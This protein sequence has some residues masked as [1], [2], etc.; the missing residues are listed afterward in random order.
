MGVA[1]EMKTA[2]LLVD[3]APIAAAWHRQTTTATTKRRTVA[4][5]RSTVDVPATEEPQ[6]AVEAEG[7]R[8]RRVMASEWMLLLA[9]HSL[10]RP[11]RRQRTLTVRERF[12]K[13]RRMTGHFVVVVV[14]VGLGGTGLG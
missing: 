10:R 5:T 7:D 14:V 1:R 8:I 3:A 2:R 13:P 11:L 9:Q 6:R 4:S 12:R